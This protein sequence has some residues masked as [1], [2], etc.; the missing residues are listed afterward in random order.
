MFHTKFLKI[1]KK[2][3][4]Y[5]AL[6]GKN[7]ITPSSVYTRLYVGSIDYALDENEVRAL[8]DGFGPLDFVNLHKDLE[9]GRS[10]GFAFVQYVIPTFFVYFCVEC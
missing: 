3:Y 2:K 8:F 9:T 1:N 5:R 7:A 4:I 10:K 6:S